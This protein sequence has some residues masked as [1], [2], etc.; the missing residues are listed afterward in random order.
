MGFREESKANLTVV[1]YNIHRCI[2][3]DGASDPGR[4]S[5][6]LKDLNA[7]I[8]GLQEVDSSHVD[9]NG[10]SQIEHI[11]QRLGFT[12]IAG[13]S[14][15]RHNGYY[16]NALLTRHEI[17]SSRHIDLSFQ[18]RE[19]RCA[20]EVELE[21]EGRIVRVIVTHFGLTVKERSAQV[22][23]LCKAIA[24]GR[25]ETTIVLGDFNEWRWKARTSS[26]LRSYFGKSTTGRTF[27]SK[28][29]IFPLDRVFVRP[30]GALIEE[31]VY[32]TPLSRV[33]SDHLPIKAI[34]RIE[35]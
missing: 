1:S 30:S 5:T 29:P 28:F 18:G 22:D 4:I 35:Q 14:I 27:P 7:S 20:V 3:R 21:I 16:G 17:R 32:S 10:L 24:F 8:V 6:I 26:C 33:A 25:N 15:H 12:L 9:G 11:S 31:E 34:I 13:P 2:G 19:P 23:D